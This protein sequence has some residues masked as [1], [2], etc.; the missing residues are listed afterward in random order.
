[1]KKIFVVL[2]IALLVTAFSA[3]QPFAKEAGEYEILVNELVKEGVL[4]PEKAEAILAEVEAAKEKAAKEGKGFELP[5]ELEWLKRFKFTGDLRLRYQ[6]NHVENDRIRH[7]GR[8]R[9]RFG[10]KAK[11]IDDLF[12]AAGLATGGTDPR[13]TNQTMA[14]TFETPDIRFDY[15]YAQYD[16]FPWLTLKAGKIKGM[17]IWKPSD[18][19]WDGDIN[20]DGGAI[21]LD[22]TFLENSVTLEGFFNTGFFVLDEWSTRTDPF[23]YVFQPGVNVTVNDFGFKTAVTYYGFE[24]IKREFLDHNAGTN[25]TIPGIGLM[26]DYNAIGV[27]AELG[28]KKPFGQSFI[29]YVGGFGEYIHT[30]DPLDDNDGFLVGLKVGHKKVKKPWEWQVNYQYRYLEQD[31]WLD[32]FPDS[33]AYGGETNAKGHEVAFTLGIFKHVSMGVDYYYMQPI[34]GDPRPSEH[35]FQFDVVFKF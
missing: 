4:T 34:Q 27:S 10:V 29:P 23:M 33:D 12:V 26:Y 28:Y 11:V 8:Y 25:T 13:S 6:M 2:V 35:L 19:L 9:F 32:T 20:P 15:G 16:P 21:Q 3:A 7:R 5:K 24:H 22:Y 1:M 18:L 17:P 31:A 14:N 30:F